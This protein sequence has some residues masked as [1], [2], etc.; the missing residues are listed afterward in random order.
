M[1]KKR[2][3]ARIGIPQHIYADDETEFILAVDRFKAVNKVRFPTF[4]EIFR[5][6][7]MLGY[8]KGNYKKL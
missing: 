5:I 3:T 4:S 1:N 8:H 2:N 7:K 6:I